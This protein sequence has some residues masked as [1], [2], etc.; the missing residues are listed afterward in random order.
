MWKAIAEKT[1]ATPESF[2]ALF[3]I[4]TFMAPLVTLTLPLNMNGISRAVYQLDR[5]TVRGQFKP[6]LLAQKS[7]SPRLLRPAVAELVNRR[8]NHGPA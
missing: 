4:A 2:I 7:H 3:I 5:K 8:L 1:P 6:G